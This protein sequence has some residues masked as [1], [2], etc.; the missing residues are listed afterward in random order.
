MVGFWDN[1]MPLPFSGKPS[2]SQRFPHDNKDYNWAKLAIS[3]SG[4]LLL[5]KTKVKRNNYT[6]QQVRGARLTKIWS[7]T[8]EA[9][10]QEE[11]NEDKDVCPQYDTCFQGF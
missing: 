6:L 8:M 2:A 9:S 5:D 3:H 4:S 10:S 7:K 11:N 1:I